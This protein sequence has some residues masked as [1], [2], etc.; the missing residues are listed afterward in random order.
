MKDSLRR[1]LVDSHV[2]PI[3]ITL[4]LARS[5][6]EGIDGLTPPIAYSILG[7][8]IFLITAVTERELPQI[9]LSLS[10]PDLF[11]LLKG[12]PHLVDAASCAFA[13]WLLSRWVYGQ[14]PLCSL[15]IAWSQRPRR[16]N[17][18]SLE[19]GACR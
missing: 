3:A 18:S 16:S 13:A 5:V 17:A 1:V 4:L 10:G 2:A 12:L 15:R 11:I 8:T 9:S 7:A 6:F 19:D 14:G